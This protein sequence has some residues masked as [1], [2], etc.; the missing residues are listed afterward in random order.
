MAELREREVPH[1]EENG[2][3]KSKLA[4]ED[5][6]GEKVGLK[7]QVSLVSGIAL[8]VGTMI[9][10]GIFVSP[11]GVLRQTESV[12]MSLIIWLLCGII[13]MFGALC[14]AELGT[15]ITKSGGEYVYLYET[16]GP[17]PA[18]LF[19]WTSIMVLKPSSVAA[20]A[21]SFGAYIADPF[22]PDDCEPPTLAVKL[23]A[24]LCILMIV[25]VNCASVKWATSVQNFF[26]AAKLLALVIIILVG[27]VK[28]CQGNTQYLKLSVSFDGSATDLFAYGV[29]FYQGLWAYDG[30]NQLN[31]ITEELIKPHTNL[32]RAIMI[33]IPLVTILYLLVNISY[34]TVMS[35][36]ELLASGA[37]AVTFSQRTLGPMAWIMPIFVCC[38]TFGACNGS[39][40]TSGRLAY[41][42]AREGHMVEVISMVH[43]KRYT[44]FPALVFT[45]LVAIIML[46]PGD[47]ESLVN[48]FSFSAWLFYGGTVSALLV[49]RYREPD[50]YRPIKVPLFIPIVILI[51]SVYLIIAPIID[52]PAM[53]YLYAF[54][55]IIAGLIF[56]FPFVH[57]RYHPKFMGKV[58]HFFQLLFEVAPSAYEVPEIGEDG[59]M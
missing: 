21:L 28:I 55:F 2:I 46:I 10:S 57:F 40:F 43:V 11:K 33:G 35:P 42:A 48:Y 25:F 19:S 24:A 52:E 44:P 18:Y 8:I 16:L 3:D 32:P 59:K 13:S 12:G 53:A 56:Y 7:R 51:C 36:D 22:F 47:F 49:L 45:S 50:I 54:L 23:F 31:Y 38:S 20:I 37:V 27:F 58:T 5:D 6:P 1:K 29:A 26:T 4:L 17:I 41:V 9:G 15:I 39:L 34:F 14:Y 30:W